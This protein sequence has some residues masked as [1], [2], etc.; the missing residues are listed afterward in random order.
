VKRR[1]RKV[2]RHL[3][4]SAQLAS[5][6]VM[7]WFVWRNATLWFGFQ[8]FIG[9]LAEASIYA[10]FTWGISA[11]ITGWIYIVVSK[12]DFEPARVSLS[13]SMQGVW[14]APAI[15]LMTALTPAA[16]AVS[17]ALLINTTRL[18]VKTWVRPQPDAIGDEAPR[19]V[20]L[21]SA[22]M[23]QFAVIAVLWNSPFIAA[24]L[25]SASIAVVT[26]HSIVWGAY[27]PRKAPAAPPSP[28]GVAVTF[29]LATMISAGGMQMSMGS[30]SAGDPASPQ[31]FQ[32]TRTMLRRLF[33]SDRP[34]AD[35]LA[36]AAP[37]ERST[38]VTELYTEEPREKARG[39]GGFPGVILKPDAEPPKKL[40][41]PVPQR[42]ALFGTGMRKEV[43]IPFSGE[44]WMYQFPLRRPPS[45]SSFFKRGTPFE[46]SYRTT[47]RS[48]LEMEAN[49][50][51]RQIVD[52]DCCGEIRV[53]I[54]NAAP[55]GNVELE[56]QL[57]DTTSRDARG[58][59]RYLSL[60]KLATS[61]DFAPHSES[62]HFTVTRPADFEKFDAMKVI[63]HRSP[64][65]RAKTAHVSIQRF[66]LVP[67]PL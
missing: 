47:D 2:R 21:A 52:L 42:T 10:V 1:F 39:T 29:L 45:E 46:L 11:L 24:A 30:A 25:A 49:Q 43:A 28:F 9:V 6:I 63:F 35:E 40:A 13:T 57:F 31:S 41:I 36:K 58:E 55:P 38:R 53:D 32:Y 59:A 17:L 66:V 19:W 67:R 56:L 48:A 33:D 18:I 7:T 27:K 15:I 50:R 5:L 64:L 16:I 65:L 12:G 20:A 54:M 26:A 23:A 44:Y 51:L 60:G 4:L 61:A 14:F 37:Q 3:L 34:R 22:L 8:A 62:L